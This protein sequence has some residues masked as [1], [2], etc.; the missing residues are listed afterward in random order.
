MEQK[1]KGKLEWHLLDF[2]FL[3]DMAKAMQVGKDKYEEDDWK[4]FEE[5]VSLYLDATMRHIM[6]AV[7]KG[8][9]YDPET[10]AFH[11]AHAS[12][13]LM[14]L[15]WHLQRVHGDERKQEVQDLILEG[16]S[17]VEAERQVSSKYAL[18]S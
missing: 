3:E 13:S 1:G 16:I 10:S 17:P 2:T 4:K 18:H 5:G 15:N 11:L 6:E 12:A 8:N 14:I 9:I 7:H